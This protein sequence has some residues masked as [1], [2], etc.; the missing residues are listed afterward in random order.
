MAQMMCMHHRMCMRSRQVC[1]DAPLRPASEQLADPQAS[2]GTHATRRFV[3]CRRI[4]RCIHDRL[5]KIAP[6]KICSHSL[7]VAPVVRVSQP[8]RS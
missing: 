4:S 3:H 6:D 8:G 5:Q 1:F 2:G 7:L